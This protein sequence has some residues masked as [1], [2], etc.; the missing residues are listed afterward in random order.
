MYTASSM[1]IEC[2]Y[3]SWMSNTLLYLFYD[4]MQD[5]SV[6]DEHARVCNAEPRA[7]CLH[8]DWMNCRWSSLNSTVEVS[9]FLIARD[10]D[11]ESH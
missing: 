3:E 1:L 8:F 10:V 5:S 2:G 6:T 7:R 9:S 11:I 4:G